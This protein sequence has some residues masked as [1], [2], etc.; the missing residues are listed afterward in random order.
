MKPVKNNIALDPPRADISPGPEY[1][2]DTRIFQGIPGIER[3]RGGRLWA[4]WYGG[5]DTEGPDNYVMLVTSGNDGASWS[6]L[7]LVV[8]PEGLVRA[9]D[10]CLWMDPSGRMWLFWAQAHYFWDGRGGVWA[11][12]TDEA[13][14]ENPTWS[15]PRR[16]ADGVM[17]NKPTALENGTWLLPAASWD[18][19]VKG[20]GQEFEFDMGKLTGSNVFASYDQGE[21]WALS[22]QALIPGV[23]CDEH[24]IVERTEGSLWMLAR[25]EYGIGESTSIDQGKT[26]SPGQPSWLRHIA[27]ARFCIRRLQSGNLLFVNHNSPD[28]KTRSHLTAFLSEDEGKTWQGGLLLDRRKGVSYPDITESD[29]G[30]IYCIYDYSRQDKM[31]ILMAVFTEEDILNKGKIRDFRSRVLVNKATGR[32]IDN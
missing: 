12:T 23:A 18:I 2:R 26:W 13:D 10:P 1:G 31:E 3:S 30:E 21:N 25:T 9:F 8:D 27:K 16:L 20:G 15:S 4:A 11:I 6:D 7:K 14:Q 24:M 5:G 32:R 17:M 29:S 28:G 19:P 22:G